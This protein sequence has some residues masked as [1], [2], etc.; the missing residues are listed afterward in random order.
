MADFV[1][2]IVSV[3]TALFKGLIDCLASVGELVFVAGE[4]GTISGITPFGILLGVLVGIPLATW[5]FGKA[6]TFVK[7]IATRK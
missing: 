1:S 4:S 6:F 7:S 3:L 5:L 2:N